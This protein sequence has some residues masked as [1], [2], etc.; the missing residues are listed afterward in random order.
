MSILGKDDILEIKLMRKINGK[1]VQERIQISNE[2]IF[3]MSA[4]EF[5]RHFS[6]C[7]KTAKN[8]L[9]LAEEYSS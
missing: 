9:D 1:H 8:R 2:D 5:L 3:W 4:P 7:I 6:A